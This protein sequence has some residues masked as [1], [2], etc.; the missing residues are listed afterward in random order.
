MLVYSTEVR[1]QKGTMPER[2]H[3]VVCDWLSQK[4]Y[5]TVSYGQLTDSREKVFA[6]GVRLNHVS[7]GEGYPFLESFSLSHRDAEVRGRLWITEIGAEVPSAA[8]GLRCTIVVRTDDISPKVSATT[9]TS[10]RPKLVPM[11]IEQCSASEST[12]GLKLIKLDDKDF[13]AYRYEIELPQRRYPLVVLSPRADGSYFADLEKLRSQLVSVAQVVQIPPDADTLFLEKVWGSNYS[14]WGGAICLIFPKAKYSNYYP[15]RKLLPVTLEKQRSEGIT[16]IENEI[17]AL[18]TDRTNLPISRKHIDA[19]VVREVARRRELAALRI[20]L[21]GQSQEVKDYVLLLEDENKSLNEK[22]VALEESYQQLRDSYE[23]QN[24]Q[25]GQLRYENASL[26]E[27]LKAKLT[28]GQ[29]SPIDDDSL[30]MITQ[31]V[32]SGANPRLIL[33]FLEKAFQSRLTVLDSAWKSS[34]RSSSFAHSDRLFDLLLRLCRDYWEKLSD[35]AGDTE[36]KGIFGD[37]YAAQESETVQGNR[38]AKAKRMF[39]YKGTPVEMMRHLRIGNKDSA[40]ETIRVHFYWDAQEK[41]IVIGHCGPHL[42]F[43]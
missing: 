25:I 30:E 10:T 3:S 35:G 38:G 37:S 7:S 13:E 6:S 9:P 12:P 20:K 23:Q 33:T 24:D 34:E 19:T 21:E 8:E 42:D 4:C 32:K 1:F 22:L 43:K 31:I 15:F 28:S 27:N 39:I 2:F 40:S 29:K 11:L 26:K 16:P 18:I 5:Q 14:V 36:A 17:L 41:R